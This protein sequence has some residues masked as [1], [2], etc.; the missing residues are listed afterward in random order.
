MIVSSKNIPQIGLFA[1]GTVFGGLV[2]F[3]TW[4]M[5]TPSDPSMSFLPF[6]LPYHDKIMHFVAFGM[7]VVPAGLVLPRR[8]L[9]FV[10][11][12]MVALAAGMEFAQEVSSVGRTGSIKDFIASV[13]GGGAAVL[14][15]WA[16]KKWFIDRLINRNQTVQ[17]T[18]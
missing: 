4:G 10:L 14:C 9:S 3:F 15:V 5:L 13:M 16:L 7:M 11:M 1:A 17:P 12:S 6:R 2:A 8:Y 18:S